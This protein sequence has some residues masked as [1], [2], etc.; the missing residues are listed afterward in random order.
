MKKVLLTILFFTSI[1]F[2]QT[3]DVGQ[4]NANVDQALINALV[5]DD[6]IAQHRTELNS[7]SSG[8]QNADPDLSTY[9][10]ITP[11]VNMITFLGAANYSAMRTQLSLVV[12]T[13]VQAYDADL[14]T[15]AGITPS[16]NVQSILSA[17]DYAAIR[18][19]LGL[20]I[21]TNVQAYDADLTS[22]GAITPAVF[23][24][25]LSFNINIADTVITGD[26]AIWKIPN[27]I[28]ITEVASFTNTGTVTFNIEERGE[29]TPNT[30]GTD[31]MTSDLTGDTDQQETGT[32]SNAGIARDAWLALV[33]ASKTGDPT[34]FG[35]SIRYVKTN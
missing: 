6:S 26:N 2:S 34:L 28:T 7:L 8:K 22:W 29:T 16:A 23:F 13:N 3:H 30:A 1:A 5:S 31:V 14:T 21:G 24:D 18:T 12:G 10:A 35:V 17:A 25:T 33:V 32:F 4:S 19:A 9:A 15:Y 27:N 20:V 11:S